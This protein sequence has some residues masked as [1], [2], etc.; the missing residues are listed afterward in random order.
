M[1]I[2]ETKKTERN[3]SMFADEKNHSMFADEKN[4]SKEIIVYK[5]NGTCPFLL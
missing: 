5:Y 1:L 4:H 3:H 2:P